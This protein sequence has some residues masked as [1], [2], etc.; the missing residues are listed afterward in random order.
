MRFS[1]GIPT[2]KEGLNF[3]LPFADPRDVIRVVQEAERLGYWAVWGND[4]VT[5]P[6]YVREE[7]GA[8]QPRFYEPLIALAYAAAA[9]STIRLAAGA[10]VL[11]M[12]EPVYLAKQA[13]TLDAMSGGRF[14]LGVALGAYREEF[15]A[16]HPDLKSANRGAMM[17]ESL[18]ALRALL[19]EP[20]A[21]F[22]GRFYSF[23][24]IELCPKPVQSPM[25]LYVGGNSPFAARRAARYG[26][27]WLLSPLGIDEARR[28]VELLRREAEAAGRDPSAI[29]VAVQVMVAMGDDEAES[30]RRFK[31]SQMFRH[32]MSLGSPAT[33]AEREAR[34][35][36]Y[37]LIGTPRSI[38][39]KIGR[40]AGTGI[41]HFAA[42]NFI[43]DTP[44]GMVEV[45]QR[46][47][48]DVVPAFAA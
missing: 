2:C 30:R 48:E 16:V 9:T 36:E 22:H 38:V 29:D 7:Y 31:D 3:P 27:G 17:E 11:P 25:P 13:A 1:A 6:R 14:V 24:G 10:I 15:E 46:F 5:A 44:E 8:R 39:D 43:S 34:L 42:I 40:L 18:Q 33:R 47:A 12:R 32:L 19:D 35:E 23:E 20:R 28:S 4:H 26:T 37:N 41:S 45:M 21:S